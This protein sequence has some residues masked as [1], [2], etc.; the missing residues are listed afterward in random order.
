MFTLYTSPGY[1]WILDQILSKHNSSIK[2]ITLLMKL[3]K[4]LQ[5]T[6]QTFYCGN[7]LYRMIGSG[8]LKSSILDNALYCKSLK[9]FLYPIQGICINFQFPRFV[10]DFME[11]SGQ[12]L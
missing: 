3:Y 11:E 6:T 4:Q 5:N 2:A 1:F 10:M 9:M 7:S 12:I 8:F